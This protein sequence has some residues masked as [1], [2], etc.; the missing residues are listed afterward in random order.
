MI[1]AS[2]P[3]GLMPRILLPAPGLR[4]IHVQLIV[5]MPAPWPLKVEPRS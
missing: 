4:A 1:Q 3:H 5:T 2:Y